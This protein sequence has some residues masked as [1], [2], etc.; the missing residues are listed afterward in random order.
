[1]QKMMQTS[2][3]LERDKSQNSSR[4]TRDQKVSSSMGSGPARLK[5]ESLSSRHVTSASWNILAFPGNGLRQ[6]LDRRRIVVLFGV[7]AFWC[8]DH[9]QSWRTGNTHDRNWHWKVH[10]FDHLVHFWTRQSTC[11]D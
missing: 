11:I 10:H 9:V 4:E 2:Q 8:R 3:G 7:F 5:H 6:F 1:M